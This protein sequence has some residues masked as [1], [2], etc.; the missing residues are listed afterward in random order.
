ME[1]I[2]VNVRWRVRSATS[3]WF[4][5]L[6]TLEKS[7]DVR[8]VEVGFNTAML[9]MICCQRYIVTGC[10]EVIP[11]VSFGVSTQSPYLLP[12]L[13]ETK[14]QHQKSPLQVS[15]WS[16]CWRKASISI[17]AIRGTSETCVSKLVA[18]VSF[19]LHLLTPSLALPPSCWSHKTPWKSR[20]GIWIP[21][22]GSH[23]PSWYS[24]A[25]SSEY[26]QWLKTLPSSRMNF[27]RAMRKIILS[28]STLPRLGATSLQI[29]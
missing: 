6:H 15:V 27:Q 21:S 16:G 9:I 10:G 12:P 20:F 22:S 2:F 28:T 13:S 18:T 14:L 17:M 3:Y 4:V 5:I 25:R 29:Y 11:M 19:H 26:S 23:K 8:E 1:L 7:F 24:A